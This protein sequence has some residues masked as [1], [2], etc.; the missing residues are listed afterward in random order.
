M[1]I[2]IFIII[3]GL[4]SW[5]VWSWYSSILESPKYTVLEKKNN[6]EI[7][8][9]NKYLKAEVEV[10]K[11]GDEGMNTAFR[12][13][14]NYI[15][16]DNLGKEKV[17][18]TVPVLAEEKSFN[19]LGGNGDKVSMTSPVFVTEE[20]GSTT[21]SFSMPSKFSLDTLPKTNDSRIKFIEVDEK[22][23]AAYA[24]T[25][26]YN[27]EKIAKKKKEFLEILK[28]NNIEIIGKPLFAGYNGPGT[29]PF[30]MRNEILVE[31]K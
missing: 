20:S 7:R 25:W 15:F 31:V 23:I 8:K 29:I 16:G 19:Q 26:Y 13:L 24:F 12:I 2:L 6:F 4:V 21:M 11:S 22:K 3:I 30:M 10:P 17:A 28:N 18:M 1:K 27:E 14:A 5:V 9:Y